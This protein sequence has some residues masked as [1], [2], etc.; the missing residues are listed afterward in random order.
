[1]DSKLSRFKSIQYQNK[2]N[3]LVKYYEFNKAYL[4]EKDLNNNVFLINESKSIY[5]YYKQSNTFKKIIVPE[6]NFTDI[7]SFFID[8][9]N[10]IWIITTKGVCTCYKIVKNEKNG[11]ISLLSYNKASIYKNQLLSS[12]YND[13]FI[14]LLDTKNDL[15]SYDL[16]TKTE[17]IIYNL[18]IEIKSRGKITQVYKDKD[19]FFVGFL[20]GGV[21]I[22]EKKK[23]HNEY[24]F[25][26]ID[27][28][29][30]IN[31]IVK[32]RFQDIIWIGTDGQGIYLYSETSYSIKSTVLNNE[33]YKIG[34]PIRALFLDKEQTLWI[35]SKGDGILKILNYDANKNI[36]NCKSEKQ[37]INNSLLNSNAVYCFKQSKKNILWIGT[38]EGLNYYSYKEKKI[39]QIKVDYNG[40]PFKYI[41]DIYEDKNAVLW[42][43]SVG[44]GI[45]KVQIKGTNDEP[46][47]KI[48]KHFSIENNIPSSNYFFTIFPENDSIIWFGNKG[49]GPVKFNTRTE[50]LVPLSTFKNY[51]P[52]TINDV[53]AINK[54]KLNNY[55]FGTGFGLIYYNPSGSYKIFNS[56][57]GF[58]NNTAHAIL[59][60][61]N[62]DIW[63][64]TNRGI[65]IFNPEKNIFRE[66]ENEYGQDI[67]VFGYGA[68]FKD[69]KTG[70]LFFGG[71]NGFVSI[72]ERD[73]LDPKYMPPVSF[74]KLT[75]F[76]EKNNILAFITKE[77]KNNVLKLKYYQNFFSIS[78]TAIDYLNGKNYNY[79][80]KINGLSDHWINNGHSNVAAFTNISPGSYNLLVKYYNRTDGLESQVY[81]IKI[82][83]DYPW[84]RSIWAY[85]FYAFFISI[86]IFSVIR[87]VMIQ[88]KQNEQKRLNEIEK[89]HQKEVFESKL[90]FFTNITHEFCAPL[91]LIS[92]PCDR[93]LAQ[94]DVSKFIGNYVQMIKTNANRLTGLIQELIEFRKIE[95]EIRDMQIELMPIS[96]PVANTIEAFKVMAE[97]KN[98]NF[99]TK[100]PDTLEW[101]T[102]KGF[103]MSIVIN[104]LSNAFKYT[105]NGKNIKLDIFI[106]NH[107]LTLEIANEGNIDEGDFVH[108]FDRY[109]ILENFEK[110]DGGQYFS[111]TGL[112]LAISSNM[113]KLLKGTITVEKTQNNWVL[114]QVILPKIEI[115][116]N[117]ISGTNVQRYIPSVETPMTIT[118]H[119]DEIDRLK[120]TILIIDDDVE[121]LWFIS[122]IFSDQFNTIRLQDPTKIDQILN[123]FYPD[124]IISDILMS[125]MNGIDL[126]RK[127]KGSKSTNQI[128]IML[129]SSNHNI[130]QQI[131]ALSLGAEM[132]ITKPFNTE[133]LKIAVTQ[134]FERKEKFK[135]YLSS[136]I[137][138]FQMTEGKLT[139][140]EHRKFLQSVLSIIND[141]IADPNLS[142]QFIADKLG[143][144]SRSLYRRMEEIG[145][146]SPTNLIR[147]SRLFVTRN[148][149][150]QTNLT[151]DEIM[152]KSGFLSKVTYFKTFSNKYNCT[153]KEYRQKNNNEISM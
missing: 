70:T 9:E 38:E 120:H 151:I 10:I 137:S 51:K 73:I 37:A 85:C 22:L 114:F 17:K 59:H 78:F 130:D 16:S 25:T 100:V 87:Y 64:S 1:M 80:Y 13:N 94:N 122:E 111:R 97:S 89:K 104:L 76:G 115:T 102:D 12:Y 19:R 65:F 96:E 72:I 99:E 125:G 140:I 126:I 108:I 98:I 141:N 95:T 26:D 54:D 90:D 66:F 52:N 58:L 30:G 144:G 3:K 11:L 153:P 109:T 15:H 91:T 50:T 33:M 128:P 2:T 47:L 20:L 48:I 149:L 49:F 14:N 27:I 4:I 81:S 150:V 75:V 62:N 131:Q 36:T 106:K 21:I 83:I 118:L 68:A 53:I 40:L 79:Y 113:V 63:L 132:Y 124:L 24:T 145:E 103:F 143:I 138:S 116:K 129:V 7:S 84:Y 152:H 71:I 105:P 57:N 31:C 92:G 119:E 60:G 29:C 133:F 148:L 5:Y 42:L 117:R 41:H 23:G 112:G 74:D 45:L 82:Q 6:L 69:E 35:G 134:L 136:P 56:K 8:K 34:H 61:N 88:I 44:M 28:N 121:M 67:V 110:H 39:K 55:L 18:S 93:I 77:D 86:F 139:H 123:K 46:V 101:N 147:E 135:D 107:C 146:D 43:A 142:T 127:I 32:D